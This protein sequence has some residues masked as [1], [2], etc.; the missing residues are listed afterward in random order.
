MLKSGYSLIFSR[1]N[2]AWRSGGELCFWVLYYHCLAPNSPFL[3]KAIK[4]MITVSCH[5]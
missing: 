2:K 4:N 5:T 1:Q 3:V